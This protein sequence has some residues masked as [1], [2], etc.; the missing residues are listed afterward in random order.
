MSKWVA[1]LKKKC[2]TTSSS[3]LLHEGN[4]LELRNHVGNLFLLVHVSPLWPLFEFV[5][6]CLSTRAKIH[7]LPVSRDVLKDYL[8]CYYDNVIILLQYYIH[9]F[10]CKCII[11]VATFCSNTWTLDSNIA[12]KYVKHALLRN[13]SQLWQYFKWI[14]CNFIIMAATF[15]PNIE[16]RN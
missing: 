16:I 8:M 5:S 9:L 2:F 15:N 13:I 6:K 10:Y 4:M 14:Y 12:I 1:Y 3:M 7:N 11:I